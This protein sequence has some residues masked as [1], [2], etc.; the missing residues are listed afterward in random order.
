M[1]HTAYQSLL[2]LFCLVP[3]SAAEVHRWFVADN[4]AALVQIEGES[5]DYFGVYHSRHPH[6]IYGQRRDA[7]ASPSLLGV[8]QATA[9]RSKTEDRAYVWVEASPVAPGLEREEPHFLKSL[10]ALVD[11]PLHVHGHPNGQT[12][13]GNSRPSIDL[14]WSGYDAA[15]LSVPKLILPRLDMYLPR[16][17]EPVLIPE[18]PLPF[19][20]TYEEDPRIKEILANLRF[21]ADVASILS[22]L[23]LAQ[24][25]EDVRWLT[26]EASDII[27]RHSF[28][29]G[30]RIAAHWLKKQFESTGAVCELQPFLEGFAP[31]VR[32]LYESGRNNNTTVILSAHYDSRG[33][34]GRWAWYAMNEMEHTETYSIS[35]R[36]PGGDDD[37][38]GTAGLLAI[39]RAIERK[40]VKFGVNVELIAFAGEEQGLLGSR[41][42]A[43]QSTSHSALAR[44]SCSYSPT[45]Q[46]IRGCSS[47]DPK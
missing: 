30:S 25:V 40:S 46:E 8:E 41:A 47:Y 13:M 19:Q 31:N 18:E 1:F 14:I 44:F 4:P 26:G 29:D 7:A 39:A 28:S 9:Q 36:A 45:S 17:F 27:S 43:S 12:P 38:S 35:T 23:S 16:F 10:V 15:I 21:D 24:M 22:G 6:Y 11:S 20:L 32:C 33:S 34:F 2:L 5:W 37:G 3:L 42:Y